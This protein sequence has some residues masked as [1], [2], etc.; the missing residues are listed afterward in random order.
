MN[1]KVLLELLLEPFPLVFPAGELIL[2][3]KS[4]TTKEEKPIKVHS[5]HNIYQVSD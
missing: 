5:K 2:K 1:R 4:D 3:S